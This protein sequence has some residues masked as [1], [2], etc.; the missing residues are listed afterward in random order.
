MYKKTVKYEDLDGNKQEE[1]LYFNYSVDEILNTLAK[2][3]VNVEN[4]EEYVHKL[5]ESEDVTTM[6]HFI[7]TLIADAYGERSEDAKHFIKTDELKK[8]FEDSVVFD[9]VMM[10]FF[11]KPEE[12][13]TF[14]ASTTQSLQKL[15]GTK[16]AKK[17]AR[18]ST[19]LSAVKN[20]KA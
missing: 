13:E 14:I 6:I 11:Q 1:T 2:L 17:P 15:N 9:E 7:H 12:F 8:D 3:D 18:R 20:T 10:D 19:K 5:V 16:A 4:I